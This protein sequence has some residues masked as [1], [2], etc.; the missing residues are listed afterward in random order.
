M[1]IILYTSECEH[2]GASLSK[3]QEDVVY[4]PFP[5]AQRGR[6]REHPL[7]ACRNLYVYMLVLETFLPCFGSLCFPPKAYMQYL[8]LHHA[9]LASLCSAV[10]PE[11]VSRSHCLLLRSHSCLCIG[12]LI[13]FKTFI[14]KYTVYR[15]FLVKG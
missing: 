11:L 14:D 2:C 12:C 5:V 9:S 13:H 1:Y 6:D 3:L 10:S 15:R 7:S 4:R 8:S